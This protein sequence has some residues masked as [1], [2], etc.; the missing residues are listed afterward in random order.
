MGGSPPETDPPAYTVR[1]SGRAKRARINVSPAG[2][3]EVVVPAGFPKRQVPEL[4]AA[5]RQWLERALERVRRRQAEHPEL[6]QGLPERIHLPA[7]DREWAVVYP[8]SG[9]AGARE[10]ADGQLRVHAPDRRGARDA[11]CNWLAR[12]AHA[13]LVPWA[14]SVA[15]ELGL[16]TRGVRVRAQ[17]RRWGSCSERGNLNLNRNLLFLAPEVVHY[18]LVHEL[19]HT[20]H[21]DHS[22]DFWALVARL[23]PDYRALDRQLRRAA[24]QV[25]VWALADRLLPSDFFDEPGTHPLAGV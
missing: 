13:H 14:G 24:G 8:G 10:S 17:A 22:P 16:T 7:L 2:R 9:K 15:E 19:A 12:T 6:H 23:E 1:E 20:V 3:V 18:L 25:P 21:M 5:N 4:V 11:L